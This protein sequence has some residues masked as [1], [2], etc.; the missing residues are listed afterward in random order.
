MPTRRHLLGTVGL[1]ATGAGCM[2]VLG[3]E[4]EDSE[5]AAP[6]ASNPAYL[7]ELSIENN[8]DRVHAVQLAVEADGE[9][10]YLDS[11]ELGANGESTTI[12]GAW[13]DE[14]D[15]Y[16]IHARIDDGD[17][18]T[19]TV[20]EHDGEAD[21]VRVLVRIETGGELA[22]WSGSDCDDI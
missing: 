18:R 2:G 1:A 17:I 8:D 20:S 15:T 13:T 22:V 7:R 5:E 10:L 3:E 6:A 9:V 14:A 11:Y 16:R 4:S 12:E 19:T 21:C